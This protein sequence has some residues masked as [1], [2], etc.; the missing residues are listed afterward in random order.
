[1]LR[2]MAGHHPSD[3]DSATVPVPDYLEAL[4]DAGDLAGLRVG[5]DRQHH[6][7]PDADP[8]LRPSFDA[9][10][11]ALEGLG[12]TLVDV[13]LPYWQELNTATMLILAAEG[14]AYHRQ[15]L[16]GRWDDYFVASRALLV[17]GAA[18]SG[19]DVVQA[20]RV[21]RVAQRSL[22]Q[23][24]STVDVVVGPTAAGGAIGYDD[25]D[26][27]VAIDQLV[28]GIFT[29]YW[30]ATGSPALV[31]PMGFTRAGLPLSLQIAGRPFEEALLFRVGDAYQRATDWHRQ[32]PP[33]VAELEAV[34]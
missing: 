13:S 14:A 11:A 30:N 7:P 34:A 25:D 10:V 17:R 9:A 19:A 29:P 20:H 22:G 6:F 24:F 26:R 5:V 3:P 15:D 21:R 2:V 23:L 32:V 1:M 8:D 33:V 4:T 27:L 18:A 16:V 28:R 31:V 12:A